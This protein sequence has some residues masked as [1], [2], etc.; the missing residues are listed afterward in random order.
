MW[1]T[2]LHTSPAALSHSPPLSFPAQDVFTEAFLNPPG[3]LGSHCQGGKWHTSPF[4][5][6]IGQQ[7]YVLLFPNFCCKLFFFSVAFLPPWEFRC[8]WLVQTC[9]RDSFQSKPL[10]L[11][12][13]RQGNF[14]LK[15]PSAE[16]LALVF[17]LLFAA[18][19]KLGAQEQQPGFSTGA[20]CCQGQQFTVKAGTGVCLSDSTL[21]SLCTFP[22]L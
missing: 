7:H 9:P 2:G 19:S 1:H 16:L 12:Q 4:T 5:A 14:C 21:R 10:N 6:L 22:I 8:H 15:P 20:G 17:F 13:V 3:V 18:P 11:L